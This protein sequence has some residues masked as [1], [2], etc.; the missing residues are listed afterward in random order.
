MSKF[1]LRSFLVSLITIIL[2]C[3]AYISLKFSIPGFLFL[4]VPVLGLLIP[5]VAEVM[6]R[7]S[8]SQEGS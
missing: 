3:P 6:E 2:V 7:G 4:Y 5:G 8:D 1:L